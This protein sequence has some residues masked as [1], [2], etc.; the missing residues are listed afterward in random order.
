MTENTNTI[1]E[2]NS[3]IVLD[4][5]VRNWDECTSYQSESNLEKELIQD[6]INQG[7][8]FLQ[9]LKSR[10]SM[11]ENVRIHLQKLNDVSFSDHEWQRFVINYLDKPSDSI[12]DKARKIHEDYIHDF[13]FDD[14]RIKNISLLDK[15][16]DRKSV[17]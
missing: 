4:K 16:K 6:L 8:E 11:L 12:T 15:K 1:A 7:Y 9:N 17:V 2:S 5:Y 13:V 3:F 14:G 10:D